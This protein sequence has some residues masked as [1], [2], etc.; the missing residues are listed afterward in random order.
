MMKLPRRSR[1]GRMFLFILKSVENEFLNSK[2][3][4]TVQIVNLHERVKKNF[5]D[6]EEFV[7]FEVVCC[8]F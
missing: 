6:I 1:L 2:A 5:V 7:K 8:K 4:F 3:F